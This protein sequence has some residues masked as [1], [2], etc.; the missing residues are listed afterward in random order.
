MAHSS[1]ESQIF[2]RDRIRDNTELL[3]N[4]FGCNVYGR[5]DF[6]LDN[7]GKPFFLEMNTL[8][9]MTSTSLFPKAAKSAG[10]EFSELIDTIIKI[11]I[12]E[13]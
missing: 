5:A 12:M 4:L 7:S 9:G 3:F 10:L 8:P 13:K 1:R 11:A 2:S 6:I